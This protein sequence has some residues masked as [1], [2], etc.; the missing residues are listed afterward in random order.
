MFCFIICKKFFRLKKR[1]EPFSIYRKNQ[2]I[3]VEKAERCPLRQRFF[4]RCQ[5]KTSAESIH[6]LHAMN[7]FQ[8]LKPV[9]T[10]FLLPF[11]F[12]GTSLRDRVLRG[13][14]S[15]A[16]HCLAA[17]ALRPLRPLVHCQLHHI[18]QK[19]YSKQD[20]TSKL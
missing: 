6:I 13:S 15:N 7:L 14:A 17:T 4:V 11:P 19:K 16:L 2:F 1:H 3:P 20:K 9:N 12:S 18:P 8:Q 10:V 5:F